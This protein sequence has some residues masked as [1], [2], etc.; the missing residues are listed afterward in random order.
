M[1]RT[2]VILF[3]VLAVGAAEPAYSL[4]YDLGIRYGV[5][6]S[7]LGQDPMIQGYADRLTFL[8][9]MVSNELI[10]TKLFRLELDLIFNERGFREK[11]GDQTSHS[12]YFLDIPVTVKVY[13]VKFLYLGA[14]FGF[15]YKLKTRNYDSNAYARFIQGIDNFVDVKTS[16]YEANFVLLL[17]VTFQVHRNI[18]LVG[19]VRHTYSM[20]NMNAHESLSY[21]YRDNDIVERYRSLYFFAG[22]SFRIVR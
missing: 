10:F 22:V 15:G 21:F 2:L 7:S 4:G 5:N 16:D 17:G 19:E 11:R 18:S 20:N 8:N 3:F 14:G 6:L 12:L 13:P 9:F 1:K